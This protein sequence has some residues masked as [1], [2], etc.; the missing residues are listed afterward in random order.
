MPHR[1]LLTF[2]LIG[3]LILTGSEARGKDW[4]P[5]QATKNGDIFYFDPDS[6]ET[7]PEGRVKVWVKIEKTEF[8]GDDLK[9]HVE[10]VIAGK[11]DSVTGEIIQFLEID[12]PDKKFRIINLAVYDKNKDIKEYYNDPSDW[13]AI[14]PQS[15]THFLQQEVCKP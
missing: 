14:A 13:E 6:L 4:K 8:R 1:S 15:V 12:C 10:N 11:T 2:T 3:F 9:K 5:Y 7:L